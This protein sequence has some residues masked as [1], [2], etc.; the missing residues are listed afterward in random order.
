MR[1]EPNVAEYTRRKGVCRKYLGHRWNNE[2]ITTYK[3]LWELSWEL[4][5]MWEKMGCA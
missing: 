2:G 5:K 3:E 1:R 4:T